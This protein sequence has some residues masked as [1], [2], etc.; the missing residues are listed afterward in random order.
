M[1]DVAQAYRD[2]WGRLLALLVRQFR[3]FEIAEDALAEAFAAASARWP[4][5]GV[6]DNPPAWLLTAARR[7]AVDRLRRR[8]VAERHAPRL[9]VDEASADDETDDRLRLVFTC[10]HPVLAPEARVA[11]T[12]RCVAGL[13]TAQIAALFLVGESTMAARLTRAKKKIV[14]A[15]VPYR[16]PQPEDL[17]ERLDSVLSVVYLVFTE[18]YQARQGTQL[19]DVDVAA[20]A[21]RL[22][23]QLSD[24]MPREA[25]ITALSALLLLQHSRRD[26]RVDA[27]GDVILLP[28]QDR[29]LWR[30]DEIKRAARMLRGLFRRGVPDSRYFLEAQI[31]AEHCVAADPADVDWPRIAA[32]YERLEQLTGS[33]AVRLNWAVAAAEADGPQAGMDLLEGLDERLP[34]HH[35]LHAARA[36]LLTRLGRA[37]EAVAAYDRAIQLANTDAERRFLN[38]KRDAARA[39][40]PLQSD[41]PSGRA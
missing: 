36:D 4:G 8:D 14:A 34:R 27:A 5:G 22:A 7:R 2:H 6:P 25:E 29:S 21:I 13:S 39:G 33:P 26:A 23:G 19:L 40:V 18:G 9:I 1:C 12:L 32:L 37:V 28:D 41:D 17:P 38:A 24:L 15:G 30:R 10:C 20:E 16:V 3:D 11:L 35:M 31:A